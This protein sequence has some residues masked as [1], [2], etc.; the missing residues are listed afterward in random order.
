MPTS[1]DPRVAPPSGRAP[2]D[3][4]PDGSGRRATWVLVITS[5]TQLLVVLDGTIVGVALPHAQADLGLSDSARQW[6]VTAYALA[7]G[8][9]LLL[10]GRVADFAGR[11]RTF[12]AGLVGFGA[13][14]VWGG[15]A[16]TGAELVLA[17]AGQG[18]F[19]ALMAP[20]ALAILTT[21][22]PGG[23]ER[24]RAFAVFGAVSGAGAAVGL[25]GGGVLTDL[26]SWRWCLLVN[27][28]FVLAG[29]VAGALLLQ[30]SRA[31]GERRYDVPGAVAV[32][33]GFGLLVYGLTAFEDAS[34]T[35]LAVVLVAAGALLLALFVLVEHRSAHPLLPLRVV[36]DRV[37]AGALAVQALVGAVMVG[38]MLYLTFHL[39]VVLQLSPLLSGL[40][41]LPITLAISATV[42][43]AARMLD[44]LGPRRQ[45][46]VGPLVGALGVGLLTQVS[47]GGSY[48]TQVLPGL[49]V[50]G[51]GMGLTLVPLQNVALL[52]VDA[53]DSGAA[54]AAVTAANQ[55]G[56]SVGLAVLTTAYVAVAGTTGAPERLVDGYAVV[57]WGGAALLVL[58][59][60]AAA[61]A[62]PRGTRVSGAS[63]AGVPAVH[64]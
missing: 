4:R 9:L 36:T 52:G 12:L 30:E 5:V 47:V 24:T 59:A 35:A 10:G 40:G 29:V 54:S 53:R 49:L 19:A 45:L 23:P 33:A 38:A 15:L 61:V 48:W 63:D 14:S 42:P 8:A 17:R 22:F 18:V 34:R 31:A 37:R 6:V 46:V 3:P 57:F 62:V 39:Q 2:A 64:V 51:V 1:A 50:F 27:V 20:A 60:V 43:Q 16:G 55:L 11:K 13:A 44:R 41:T 28:P 7:F 32:T 26:L 58:A 56:G 25:L 21:T